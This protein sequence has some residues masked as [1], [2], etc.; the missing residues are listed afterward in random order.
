VLTSLGN[1]IV[2]AAVAQAP[3]RIPGA[4]AD[5]LLA[6]LCGDTVTNVRYS[7][8][9]AIGERPP[10]SVLALAISSLALKE[11]ALQVRAKLGSGGLV[12]QRVPTRSRNGESR[13]KSC[14]VAPSGLLAE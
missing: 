5:T 9:D 6:G 14:R 2:R 1:P 8:A 12:T 13:V 10:S 4:D 7:A 11:T 3:R